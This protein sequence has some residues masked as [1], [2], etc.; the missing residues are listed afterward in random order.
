MPVPQAKITVESC[1]ALSGL[2][3]T[4][5]FN[6][7]DRNASVEPADQPWQKNTLNKGEKSTVHTEVMRMAEEI[8]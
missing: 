8:N 2:D 5:S 1:N 7:S 4:K 3:S 6:R